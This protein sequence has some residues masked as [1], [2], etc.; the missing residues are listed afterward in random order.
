MV[1]TFVFAGLALVGVHHL[2]QDL[3]TVFVFAISLTLW[4]VLAY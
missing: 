4:D 2:K 3:L 1:L